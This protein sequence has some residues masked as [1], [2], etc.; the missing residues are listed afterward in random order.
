MP[1]DVVTFVEKEVGNIIRARKKT[2]SPQLLKELKDA[3]KIDAIQK[4]V[5]GPP[6]P[7]FRPE[8]QD[9]IH[10]QQLGTLVRSLTQFV[11]A[12]TKSV[13]QI[14][15]NEFRTGYNQWKS[16]RA[17]RTM[18]HRYHDIADAGQ[19]LAAKDEAIAKI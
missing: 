15:A 17:F 10:K 2:L 1:F 8:R 14:G 7:G 11:A 4:V 18:A 5:N 3:F 6:S 16:T 9:K 13:A 19:R 12:S